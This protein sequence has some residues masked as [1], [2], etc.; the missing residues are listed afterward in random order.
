MTTNYHTDVA[1]GAAANAATVNAP[2]GQIDAK[3]NPTVGSYSDTS[4]Q[5]VTVTTAGTFYA[6][7]GPIEVSFTPAFSGQVFEILF[8]SGVVYSNT[9]GRVLLNVRIVDGAN[10]T[11][12]DQFHPG[13]VDGRHDVVVWRVRLASRCWTAG[14]GDVGVTRKA[15]VYAT[16][17]VN[18]SVAHC[19]QN[20]LQAVYR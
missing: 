7:G 15:K 17:T 11:V 12:L 10:A 5:S 3:L 18:G 14:A 8:F 6:M 2:L 13:R 16:H 1:N 20:S 4:D 9:A 19:S